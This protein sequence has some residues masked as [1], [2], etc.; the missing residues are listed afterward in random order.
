MQVTEQRVL[1]V[2]TNRSPRLTDVE[3][4]RRGDVARACWEDGRRWSLYASNHPWHDITPPASQPE[5]STV[6]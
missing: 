4:A 2:G 5:R 3:A 6:G 1:G